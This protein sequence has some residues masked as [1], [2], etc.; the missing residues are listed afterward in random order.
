MRMLAALTLNITEPTPPIPRSTS[1][2]QYA[3][4]K[5]AS[6]LD[7]ATNPMPND[8][9]TRSPNAFTSRPTNG[10]VTSR[11]TANALMTA[12]AAVLPTPN[13]RANN[14]I[15]GA[16]TPK[17]SA[18]MNATTISA[19]TSAGSTPKEV[20]R[21]LC[22]ALP[23]STAGERD[24]VAVRLR[25]RV[26]ALGHRFGDRGGCRRVLVHEDE[27]DLAALVDLGDLDLD[28]VADVHDVLDLA[29]ALAAAELA[30]V[31]QAVLA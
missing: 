6:R 24:T 29:D 9:I 23:S 10:A 12:L 21:R 2:C 19:R 15:A 13:W 1:N 4:A 11:I 18:T 14:G 3:C 30:D 28:L 5:P 7:T 31:D 22:R 20:R 8:N 17:P 26:G 25:L 27:A 16:T